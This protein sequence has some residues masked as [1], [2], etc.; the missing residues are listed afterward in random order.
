VA[1]ALNPRPRVRGRAATAAWWFA[2]LAAIGYLVTM[3]VSGALPRQRQLVRFEANGLMRTAPEAVT[4][5]DLERRGRQVTLVRGSD[6]RWQ[7]LPASAP[8]TAP[9]AGAQA[10]AAAGAHGAGA[11]AAGAE[12]GA[13]A[14]QAGP[15]ADGTETVSDAVAVKLTMAVQL[16]HTAAPIRRLEGATLTS[17]STAQFGLADG[18]LAIRLWTAPSTLTPLLAVRFGAHNPEDTAQYM[19]LDGRD[20]LYLMS[21][22]VGAEW[23]AVATSVLPP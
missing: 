6:G 5:V 17:N 8:A 16:M 15:R 19:A 10:Q 9:E 14:P 4:R 7:A 1:S 2:A 22:F 18:S 23:N 20:G 12:G 11:A 3:V 21:R 13:T